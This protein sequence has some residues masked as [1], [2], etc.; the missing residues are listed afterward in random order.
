MTR[1]RITQSDLLQWS[2][3]NT[4]TAAEDTTGPSQV[5]TEP[6]DPK[7]VDIILGKPDAVR[8]K[9]TMETIENKEM[10]MTVRIEAFDE[11]ELLVESIDNAN[12]LRPL[13]LWPKLLQL[14]E[15]EPEDELR[16]YAAW[17]I[18]TAVQNNE[19]AQQDFIFFQGLPVVMKALEKDG[20]LKV[21]QKSL[22]SL[23]G[24]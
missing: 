6:I 18:G 15:Q 23:S 7:W 19:K 16:M 14:L 24:K 5:N 21:K 4:A 20:N 2:I 3:I 22:Y 11:L 17:V 10:D 13:G 9:D 12:D 8:M 1:Q